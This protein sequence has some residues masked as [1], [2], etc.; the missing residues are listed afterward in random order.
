[1]KT[2]FTLLALF[3]FSL[4]SNAQVLCIQCYNQ[5]ARVLTDTNNLI[6]NG[7]F[8]NTTCPPYAGDS[9]YDTT[10]CP[11][12]THHKCNIVNWICT[13]GGPGTYADV[14]DSSFSIITEGNKAVYF[15]NNHANICSAG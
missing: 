8:E 7:G 12:S 1:M 5:N 6:V 9:N 4:S 13:G 10:F 14:C 15:G 11:N 2:I 3:I